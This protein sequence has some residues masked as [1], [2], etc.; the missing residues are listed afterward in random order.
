MVHCKT[1]K[2]QK[3]WMLGRAVIEEKE[4]RQPHCNVA[5]P[6]ADVH[7]RL[8]QLLLLLLVS[9][10][11]FVEAYTDSMHHIKHRNSRYKMDWNWKLRCTCDSAAGGQFGSVR[12]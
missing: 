5:D 11:D 6:K 2:R 10:C 9:E 7:M 1:Q 12:G 4:Q 3:Y 8:S